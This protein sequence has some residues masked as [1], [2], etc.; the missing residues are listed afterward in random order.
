MGDVAFQD[1][2]PGNHCFG[3][4]A[5]NPRGLQI[6]SY[7]D[8]DESVCAFQPQPHHSAGPRQYLNG[9][10]IATLIDCHCICTAIANAYRRAGRNIGEAPE[11]WYVTG[12]MNVS[13]IKPTPID[14]RVT[15]R[16][17]VIEE[18]AKKMVVQCSLSSGDSECARGDVVAIRVP[19]EWRK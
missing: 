1:G 17:R 10:I 4:G 8:G 12:A 2:I 11:I 15:L 19:N 3:C 9:G 13:Y 7:W 14:R 6:K 16:A 18:K 5:E